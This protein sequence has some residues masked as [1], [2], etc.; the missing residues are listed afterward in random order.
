[1]QQLYVSELEVGVCVYTGRHV[2]I[3]IYLSLDES[4]NLML[5]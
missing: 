4:H 2:Y 3:F 1:M 5:N